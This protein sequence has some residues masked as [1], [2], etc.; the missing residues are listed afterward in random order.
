MDS[1]N[2]GGPY[3]RVTKCLYLHKRQLMMKIIEQNGPERD[4]QGE[5]GHIRFDT[6]SFNLQEEN[7]RD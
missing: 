3:L 5:E 1:V 6:I 7:R 2:S 4:M